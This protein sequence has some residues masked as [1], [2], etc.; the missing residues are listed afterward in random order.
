M[1]ILIVSTA[2]KLWLLLCISELNVSI[3]MA[4]SVVVDP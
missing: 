4:A 2:L 1:F 3:S